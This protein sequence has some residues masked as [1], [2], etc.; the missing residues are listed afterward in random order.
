M[1]ELTL[2]LSAFPLKF[3]QKNHSISGNIG[4]YKQLLMWEPKLENVAVVLHQKTKCL[5]NIRMKFPYI[6]NKQRQHSLKCHNSNCKQ[7]RCIWMKGH[8]FRQTATNRAANCI[9]IETPFEQCAIV[10]TL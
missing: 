7:Q 5:Q 1:F 3:S 6:N 8:T 2:E 4:C 10:M 9:L